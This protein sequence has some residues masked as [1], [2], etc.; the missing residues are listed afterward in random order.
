MAGNDAGAWR[1][2]G[3]S[4]AWE[5][6]TTHSVLNSIRLPEPGRTV[7]LPHRGGRSAT[8]PKSRLTAS[9]LSCYHGDVRCH[10]I[11][12][13]RGLA[14]REPEREAVKGRG[15]FA[16]ALAVMHS[17]GSQRLVPWP[18]FLPT[19]G[20]SPAVHLRAF[21]ASTRSY[22]RGQRGAGPTIWTCGRRGRH[23]VRSPRWAEGTFGSPCAIC[24]GRAG[25]ADGK[26]FASDRPL[27]DAVILLGQGSSAAEPSC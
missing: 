14:L 12:F 16:I 18:L 19:D 4:L 13:T 22:N 21:E 11:R 5:D 23:R 2:L 10:T 27:A 17:W 20:M 26:G 24:V 3:A 6:Y 25:L 7:S 1:V 8:E 15:L 9:E